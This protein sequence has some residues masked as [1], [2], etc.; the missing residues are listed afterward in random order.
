MMVRVG[1]CAQ[2]QS[3]NFVSIVVEEFYEG[4]EKEKYM[5]NLS[6]K[7]NIHIEEGE[8]NLQNPMRLTGL[9]YPGR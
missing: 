3:L 2:Q 5:T 4:L 9:N 8:Q 6:I 1:F 7:M